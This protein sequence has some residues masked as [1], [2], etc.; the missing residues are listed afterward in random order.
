MAIIGIQAFVGG[1]DRV[2]QRIAGLRRA[3]VVLESD[4]NDDRAGDVVGEVEAIEVGECFLDRR[5]TARMPAQ[6]VVDLF[7]W[8]GMRQLDSIQE[9]AEEGGARY[10]GTD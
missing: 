5:P 3:D 8:V 9:A 10:R 4:I 7:I 2:E 6:I 1:P